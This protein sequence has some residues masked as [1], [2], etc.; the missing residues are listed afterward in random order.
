MLSAASCFLFVVFTFSFFF[1]L[2]SF[3]KGGVWFCSFL[4]FSS[5]E[6]LKLD[7]LIVHP[8]RSQESSE[9]QMRFQMQEEITVFFFSFLKP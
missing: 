5:K 6:G 4:F 2:S 9:W 7:L 1:F 3:Q 8:R